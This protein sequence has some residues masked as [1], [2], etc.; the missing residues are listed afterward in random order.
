MS[1]RSGSVGALGVKTPTATRP[2]VPFLTKN[3]SD[4]EVPSGGNPPVG[5]MPTAGIGL[6]SHRW[7]DPLVA[8]AAGTGAH[9]RELLRVR[10]TGVDFS[11]GVVRIPE[12]KRAYDRRSTQRVH[13]FPSVLSS[14]PSASTPGRLGVAQDSNR[15]EC[16]PVR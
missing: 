4:T 2:K 5:S 15:S 6:A 11:A 3:R 8:T 7:V 12:K 13:H 10:A 14:P 1:R 16:V 9:Q